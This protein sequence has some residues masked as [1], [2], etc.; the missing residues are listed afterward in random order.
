MAIV[1]FDKKE[2]EKLIGIKL[3]DKYYKE[4][5]P[6][7][8]APLEDI[9][10][11]SVSFEIFPNRP[12]MLSIEGFSRAVRNFIGIGKPRR[13]I[14][15]PYKIS[16][17]VDKS[18]K[19]VRPYIVCAVIKDVTIDEKMLLNIMQ[20]QEK[21]HETFGRKRKKIAIGIHDYDMIKPPF[22]YKA[23]KPDEIKFIP[24]G[25]DKEMN[26][27]DILKNHPK[28]I[29]YKHLLDGFEKYP[30]LIDS[31]ENVISFPPIINGELTRV[32]E[33]TNNLFI[34][35]TGTNLDALKS[36]LNILVT[37]MMDRGFM[38]ESVRIIYDD[39]NEIVTPDLS[40]RSIKVDL[41]YVNK[42]LGIKIDN[43][44]F[45]QFIKRMGFN[46]DN[47]V[48]IP[49]YRTDIMHPIDIVEDVAIAYGYENFIPELPN[50]FTIGRSLDKKEFENVISNIMTGMMFQEVRTMILTSKD[51][52]TEKMNVKAD[53]VETLNPKS[54]DY[55]VCRIDLIPGILN[56]F[57]QNKHVDYPQKI[58]EI[59]KVVF[60]DSSTETGAN[61][62]VLTCAAISP[63]N[64]S[65]ISSVINE[66]LK[67]LKI[68]FNII[69]CEDKRFI[70]GRVGK[71]LINGNEIGIIGEIHPSVLNK[72]KVEK[73]VALFELNVDKLFTL[74]LNQ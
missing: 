23:V 44:K 33:K 17:Y 51:D 16:V 55:S 32:N 4:V 9:N 21:I 63:G 28:G 66:L 12:D 14:S 13:Y 38:I 27:T 59:G 45:I 25:T 34:D 19:E 20:F 54:D 26:L 60:L 18:I 47:S 8:G 7:I 40:E 72:W 68:K 37:S 2:L 58:F 39:G 22:Y 24:L 61:E 10:E 36:A 65:D 30:I 52:Q 35:M 31:N 73:P 41:N 6:M 48:L 74:K 57:S 15:T 5:F 3:D 56:V 42:M 49:P 1:T 43:E 70:D 64:Y 67:S 11:S 46:F 62:K 71:I 69:P 29:S 50:I 53:L